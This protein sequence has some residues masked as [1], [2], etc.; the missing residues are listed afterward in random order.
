V[1]RPPA[2]RVGALA[3]AAGLVAGACALAFHAPTVRV[4]EVRS[5]SFR[6]TLAFADESS[7]ASE[8]STLAE[9]ALTDTVHIPA[10]ETGSA[11]VTVPFG[12]ASVNAAL[13]RLL[14]QGELEYRFTGELLAGTP[15]GDKRVPFDQRGRFRP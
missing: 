15:I 12:L 4:A 5:R 10:R 6:Y 14:R 11:E 8:W 13:A 1:T 9:G 3:S 2:R 7:G